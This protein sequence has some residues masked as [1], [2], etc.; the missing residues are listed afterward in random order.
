MTGKRKMRL[1]LSIRGLGYH[2]AAW[3]HPDM[4]ANGALD[5]RYFLRSAQIAEAAKMDMVFLAD[6]VGVRQRDEPA[7]ALCRSSQ[8][9]ELEP[10]TLLTAI[11]AHTSHIGLVATASTSFNEPFNIARKYASLDHIS[12]GRAGW[13]AVASWGHEEAQNFNR[14]EHYDYETRYERLAEALEVVT[15]LWNSWEDDAFVRD[16]QAGVFYDPEKLHV[17]NHQGKYFKVR[18]PL[19]SA[20]TP[21]GRPIISQA[22]ASEVGQKMAAKFADMVY[23]A[24]VE[25]EPAQA[26]YSELK[27]RLAEHGRTGDSLK[28]LPAISP[29]VGRTEQEAQDKFDYLQSLIDPLIGLQQIYRQLGDMSAY[30]LDGPVPP[31]A[32]YVEMRSDANRLYALAQH[33]SLTIRQLY[34]R[35]AAASSIRVVIGSATQIA[36]NME[37]WFTNGA[38]D[39]FNI[40]PPMLPQSAEDFTELVIPELQRRGLFRTEYEGNTLR[41]NLGLPEQRFSC[42]PN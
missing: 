27:G 12:G 29:F 25:L 37:E 26:F 21:Q 20:R 8:N 36:D 6:S 1:G 32:D 19:S 17:L 23:T 38:A 16:K 18:G 42:G 22:G 40:C 11:A 13:N 31:P 33:E 9:V 7:G 41:E 2:L 5:Y 14:S 3:R 4:Q 10:I 30:D 24:N 35:V 39:G 34:E 28:I 15:G